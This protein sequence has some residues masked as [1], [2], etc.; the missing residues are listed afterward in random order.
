MKVA[1]V[2]LSAMGDIIHAMVALQYIKQFNPTIQID[3]V[4]ELGFKS[5]LEGNPHIDNILTV[6]LKAIKKD[7]K[8]IIEQIKLVRE[9]AK[10]HYDLV[11]DAQGLV[12]SA[13]TAMLLGKNRAGFSKDS[14]REG[15]ASYFYSQKVDIAYDANTI[16]RNARVMS[17]PLGVNISPQMIHDKLPFLYYSDVSEVEQYLKQEKKNIVF[18]IGS[19]WESRN[20]PKEKFLAIANALKQNVL[21]AWGNEEEH[22]RA[23]WIADNSEFATVL[24]HI[25]LNGLK[26]VIANADL[27]IG[28]DTGPT[29][30]AWGLNVPSITIF[31]PTP[32]NRVYETTINK[33]IKSDSIVNHFKLDKND[34]SIVDIDAAK[35]VSM[36][37]ELLDA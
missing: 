31:G 29:H 8:A 7:K 9:Y 32:V 36:A 17:E 26:A 18:V 1:I 6:N 5:V 24:P 33:V 27:L 16:D 25:N 3:W 11:I 12:K 23:L 21:I 22:S 28:N 37:R 20:Y 19:T 34:F 30:M 15:V 14:I 10:R 35:V 2:K 4:V 13:M